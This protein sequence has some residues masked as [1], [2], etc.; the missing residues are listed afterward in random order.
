MNN[1]IKLL[2]TIISGWNSGDGGGCVPHHQSG[3]LV[4]GLPRATARVLRSQK[5]R[6]TIP[7]QLVPPVRQR[8]GT[9]QESTPFTPGGVALGLGRSEHLQAPYLPTG[10]ANAQPGLAAAER[11]IN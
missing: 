3:P 9:G 6:L 7:G 5:D 8:P 4:S 11:R 1:F 10:R 2:E